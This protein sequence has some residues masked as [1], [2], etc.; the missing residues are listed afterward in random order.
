M[1]FSVSSHFVM[2][3]PAATANANPIA[4]L[5]NILSSLSQEHRGYRLTQNGP[6]GVA[7]PPESTRDSAAR[8]RLFDG[9]A[10]P[11]LG[12]PRQGR[13][14]VRSSHR[15]SPTVEVMRCSDFASDAT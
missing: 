7:R 2:A 6:E 15:V 5:R 12:G 3:Y 13:P 11:C 9:R 10:H 1:P 8:S 4:S 14:G